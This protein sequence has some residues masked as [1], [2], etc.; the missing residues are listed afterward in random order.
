MKCINS[1]QNSIKIKYPKLSLYITKNLNA[2]KY[3]K[4]NLI[5]FAVIDLGKSQKY[6]LNFVCLLP[7]HIDLKTK[8]PREFSKRFGSESLN[9]AKELLSNAL[10]TDIESDVRKEIVSRLKLLTPIPKNVAKCITC[11]NDFTTRKFGYVKLTSCEDCRNK[12]REYQIKKL[13]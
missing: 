13:L 11:G 10:K 5:K 7:R 12:K 3:F 4:G 8:T 2:K 6:P 9:V 1:D